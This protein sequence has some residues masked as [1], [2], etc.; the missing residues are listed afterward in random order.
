MNIGSS[1][2]RSLAGLCPLM[3]PFASGLRASSAFLPDLVN[4][5]RATALSQTIVWR[6]VATMT[7]ETMPT[8]PQMLHPRAG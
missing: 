3:C 7:T 1:A 4:L 6:L 5:M 8:R 2:T